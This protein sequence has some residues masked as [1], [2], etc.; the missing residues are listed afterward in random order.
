MAGLC[1]QGREAK[2][3]VSDIGLNDARTWIRETNMTAPDVLRE[4]WDFS[5]RQVERVNAR[6]EDLWGLEWQ[7]RWQAKME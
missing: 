1:T 5:D 7:T 2:N 6:N 3:A 4:M